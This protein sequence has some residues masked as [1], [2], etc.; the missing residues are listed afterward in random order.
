MTANQPGRRPGGALAR[1]RLGL[2]QAVDAHEDE[3]NADNKRRKERPDR[4]QDVSRKL[5]IV[6]NRFVRR[7]TPGRLHRNLFTE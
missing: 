4:D 1:L 2:G 6:I 3:G 7:V 5:G